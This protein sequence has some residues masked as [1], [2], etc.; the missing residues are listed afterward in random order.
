MITLQRLRN[1][2]LSLRVR[3]NLRIAL[4]VVRVQR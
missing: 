4:P 1:G 2:A 3:W